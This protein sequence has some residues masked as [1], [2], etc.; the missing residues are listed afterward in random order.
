MRRGLTLIACLWA[1][2][3]SAQ[4]VKG[5]LV[6]PTPAPAVYV[7]QSAADASALSPNNG[8]QIL[9]LSDGSQR[10][11][12]GAWVNPVASAGVP[13]GVSVLIESGT[14]PA[15]YVENTALNGKA[16][17]GTLAANGNVG[18]SVG[19]DA[20]TQVLNHTH[21]VTVT[22]PGHTHVERIINSGTAGTVGVQ[23]ASAASNANA[24]NSP[25]ASAT[26]GI[27][28]ATVNPAGGVNSIDNRQASIYVIVCK[29]S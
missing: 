7:C 25:S 15:G 11:Y 8:D 13:A 6:G 16:L 17:I 9:V 28:A 26:T 2:P 3:V 24:S 5:T 22:D 12:N 19:S 1:V 29:K 21:T 27:S 23:G 14:C 18:Q 10:I 4:C 20:I